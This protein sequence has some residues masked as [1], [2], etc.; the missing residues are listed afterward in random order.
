MTPPRDDR[1]ED[2]DTKPGVHYHAH[3]LPRC[4]DRGTDWFEG[5]WLCDRHRQQ[6]EAAS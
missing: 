5:R 3:D 6:R 2:F 1:C 4:R